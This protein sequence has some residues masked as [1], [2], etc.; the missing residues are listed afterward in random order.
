LYFISRCVFTLINLDHFTDLTLPAFLRIAFF[1]MRFDLSI[2]VLL[3]SLYLALFFFPVNIDGKPRWEKFVQTIFVIVNSVAFLFEI[4]DW[5]YFSFTFKRATSDVLSMITRKAD[6]I[7]ILPHMVYEFWYIP[8]SAAVFISAIIFVNRKIVKS[9]P[10]QHSGESPG[11][12]YKGA[13]FIALALVGGL[14]AIA[15]RGGLEYIPIGI[16]DASKVTDANY[17]PIVLNTPFSI[18]NTLYANRLEELHYMEEK[19]AY[20]Y[21]DPIKQY[22]H[23]TFS[24]KNVVVIILESFGKEYTRLGRHKSYTPFL[25]SLMDQSYTFTNAFAN[26]CHSIEGVPAIIAGLPA[27]MVEPFTTSVYS[28]NKITTLPSVLKSEG[29]ATAFYHGATNGSMSFD[30]FAASAGYEKYFGRTQYHNEADYDGDWGISDEPFLQYFAAGINKMPQ[31]FF[32]TVFTITSHGPYKIPA[33]FSRP[34]PAGTPIERT[35]AY[36]DIALSEFFKKA[37]TM[38]WF[39]NTLFVISA[40]HNAPLHDDKFYARNMG[41]YSIPILFY[42]PGDTLMRGVDTN[43][44]QQIN[45]MP[46]VLDY[47]GY[48]KKFFALGNSVFSERQPF[49][50][51]M[52]SGKGQVLLNDYLLQ[53]NNMSPVAL[54]HYNPDSA[55]HYNLI[56][57]EKDIANS[58]EKFLQ[59]F[60][61]IYNDA[62]IKNKMWV[63]P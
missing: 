38:P 25:D 32:A 15:I 21:V 8:V 13:Q 24:K 59:A 62:V 18:V 33:K 10:L 50:V 7:D 34:L 35:I 17:T 58:E 63:K 11:W 42:A 37:A 40:D 30:I 55:C 47:L 20:A 54:Y 12:W 56:Y 31:P 1:A 36:T 28:T 26:A 27:L 60:S 53:T 48:N 3:N 44:M 41:N 23:S 19:E 2:S 9:T 14:S 52:L 43:L 57:K 22:N 61:Q 5:G 49:T 45:I 29:Y 16:W 39:K 51:N 4:S 6:F 46:S